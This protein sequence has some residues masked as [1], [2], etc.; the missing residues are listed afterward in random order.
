M[1]NQSINPLLMIVG[2]CGCISASSN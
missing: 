1:L 2:D